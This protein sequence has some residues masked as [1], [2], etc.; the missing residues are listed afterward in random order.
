MFISQKKI[1]FVQI[2]IFIKKHL[3]ILI[4]YVKF[5]KLTILALKIS[6]F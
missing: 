4:Q 3:N 1:F 5:L 2:N 6:K